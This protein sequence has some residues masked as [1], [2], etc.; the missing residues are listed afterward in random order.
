MFGLL[1]CLVNDAESRV[2]PLSGV[3]LL[4]WNEASQALGESTKLCPPS[5]IHP[6]LHEK[7]KEKQH[8]GGVVVDGVRMDTTHKKMME[9]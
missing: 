9:S 7:S 2:P 8:S 5:R 3:N 1:T 4:P 6:R